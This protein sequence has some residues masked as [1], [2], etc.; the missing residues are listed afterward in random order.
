M[1][2][3]ACP[4]VRSAALVSREAGARWSVARWAWAFAAVRDRRAVIY[5]KTL[6]A[7]VLV[8]V[9]VFALDLALAFA[10]ASVLLALVAS[11][12]ARAFQKRKCQK[13]W[14]ARPRRPPLSGPVGPAGPLSYKAPSLWP[15]RLPARPT[16][17]IKPGAKFKGQGA[18]RA[19]GCPVARAQPEP[20]G[21]PPLWPAKRA[22]CL[23]SRSLSAAQ[24]MGRRRAE[25]RRGG[26]P[27]SNGLGGDSEQRKCNSSSTAAARTACWPSG[28]SAI[29]FGL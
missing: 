27:S 2:S 1:L 26:G 7:Q 23:P 9:F 11:D 24:T 25:S 3:L 21:L 17:S 29:E 20:A 6:G 14:L 19:A 4:L 13:E 15:P 28:V 16:N 5:F 8:S 10:L 22:L 12:Q 18:R